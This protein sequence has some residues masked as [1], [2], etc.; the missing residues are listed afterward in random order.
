MNSAIQLIERAAPH[1]ES[2]SESG[3]FPLLNL[4]TTDITSTLL[5]LLISEVHVRQIDNGWFVCF[6]G[7]DGK[8]Y[9]Y[10]EIDAKIIA[11][12]QKKKLVHAFKYA[13]VSKHQY[14]EPL[15]EN[16]SVPIRFIN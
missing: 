11:A 15:P 1:A 12:N 6:P 4:G 8:E 2:D 10:D 5:D 16:H 14:D 3:F 13:L 7:A 9:T